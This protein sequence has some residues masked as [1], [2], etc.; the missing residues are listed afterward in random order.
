[1][2]FRY[3]SCVGVIICDINSM[4]FVSVYACRVCDAFVAMCATAHKASINQNGRPMLD[5]NVTWLNDTP[6]LFE[7][8]NARHYMK[9]HL[10]NGIIFTG[11]EIPPDVAHIQL[12]IL[13][14]GIDR[15]P[16]HT[17]NQ[18]HHSTL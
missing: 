11:D 9:R 2:L 6:G 18:H 8:G 13:V 14:G 3:L 16:D 1:M 10:S 15:R 17:T 7:G 4:G 12:T 5:A